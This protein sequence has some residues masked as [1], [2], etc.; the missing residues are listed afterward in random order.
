ML[1]V[2]RKSN[3]IKKESLANLYEKSE[4]EKITEKKY[5]TFVEK[6]K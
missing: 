1:C 4:A 6:K 2:K 5:L 3:S